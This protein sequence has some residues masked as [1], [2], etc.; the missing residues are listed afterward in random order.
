MNE[1]LIYTILKFLLTEANE[2]N[3]EV[4]FRNSRGYF[5]YQKKGD[6][7]KHK[8]KKKINET[9]IQSSMH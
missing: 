8:Q 2:P 4:V 7:W 1:L 3:E 9:R 5:L 6:S